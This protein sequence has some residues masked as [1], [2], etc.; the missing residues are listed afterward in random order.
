MQKNTPL[1][2]KPNYPVESVDHALALMEMVRDYGRVRL[3]VAARLLGV[4]VSTAH[5][6]MAMLVY[7]GYAVQ[8]ASRRYVPGPAMGLPPAG[9]SWTVEVRRR[10]HPHLEDLAHATGET[11]NL[12]VLAGTDVRFMASVEGHR[13]V[14]VGDRQGVVLPAAGVSAGK[15]MLAAMDPADVER[16]YRRRAEQDGTAFDARAHARLA[17]ELEAVRHRGFASN[18]EGTEEGICAVGMAIRD[19]SGAAVAGLSVAVPHQRYRHALE[20][21]LV[22]EVRRAREAIEADLADFTVAG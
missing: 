18:D 3:S 1:R 6:L 12:L 2:Q 9:V 5:R 14:R 4:S 16:A 8:D 7:R 21:G 17:T 10:A 11:T 19:G 20:T 13:P 15:A 22:D